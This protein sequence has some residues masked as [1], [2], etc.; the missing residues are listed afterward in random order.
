MT[1]EEEE[2][3]KPIN[4]GEPDWLDTP[5]E[6]YAPPPRHDMRCEDAPCCGC[7]PSAY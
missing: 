2:E 5:D 6:G 1:K 4:Y 3:E 7:C